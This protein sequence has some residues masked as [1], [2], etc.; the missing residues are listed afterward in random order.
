LTVALLPGCGV[1]GCGAGQVTVKAV[2]PGAA[3]PAAA[4]G[5]KGAAAAA[6]AAAP[7]AAPALSAALSVGQWVS[8]QAK[9]VLSGG[10]RAG[11]V[12]ASQTVPIK[13]RAYLPL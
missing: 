6:A 10:G 13:L 7:P 9:C 3:P 8:V 1:V 12:P 5:G 4:G 11:G 2:V